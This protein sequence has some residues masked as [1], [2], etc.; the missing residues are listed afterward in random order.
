MFLY[1]GGIFENS[2]FVHSIVLEHIV[3]WNF[4]TNSFSLASGD[5]ESLLHAMK[6]KSVRR[7]MIVLERNFINTSDC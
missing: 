6:D 4:G 5:C 1:A 7:V 2:S 3:F